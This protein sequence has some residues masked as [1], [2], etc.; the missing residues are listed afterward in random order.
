MSKRSTES[1]HFS[2]VV[3]GN[4]EFLKKGNKPTFLIESK[5]HALHAFVNGILQGSMLKIP[6][7]SCTNYGSA[8]H[9][10]DSQL[11]PRVSSSVVYL[12]LLS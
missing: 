9:S 11:Y 6:I 3:D 7:T 10:L 1:L 12:V 8:F 5:G 2:L 4:E